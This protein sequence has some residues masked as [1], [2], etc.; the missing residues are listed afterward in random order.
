HLKIGGPGLTTVNHREYANRMFANLG[1]IK[2]DFFSW[3]V[4][5]DRVEKMV[6]KMRIARQILDENGLTECESILNEW[7]YVKDWWGDDWEYSLKIMKSLKGASFLASTMLAGQYEQLDMLMYYD[8][9]PC[10]MNGMYSTDCV[11][12]K[13]KGYYPF[14]MFNQLYRNT[15]QVAVDVDGANLY[16]VGASGD[17]KVLV[18]SH[19]N[20]DEKAE[21]KSI[22]VE[23]DGV[24]SANGVKLEYYI[25]DANNDCALIR[26]EVF[27]AEKFA[28]YITVPVYTTYMLKIVNL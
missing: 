11:R 10:G 16:A 28:S 21:N 23:F 1:D 26:E 24:K 15:N 17:E 6:E 27:T 22:K 5:N 18:F 8:A 13:L 19:Y 7:N 25:L 9:R 12:D 2:P 20:D 14:Y 3:H 4:Y